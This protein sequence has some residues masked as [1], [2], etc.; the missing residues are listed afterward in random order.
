MEEK[1]SYLSFK[2]GAEYYAASVN[3]VHNI[4]E[5]T[6]ITKVPEMPKYMLGV[7]NLR[8]QVLPVIDSR[9]KFGISDTS[10][11]SNTCILVMEVNIEGSQTFVGALVDAVAEVIEIDTAEI[12][13]APSIG[14]TVRNDFIAGVYHDEEKFIMILEMD[15]VFAS[16]EIINIQ[17]IAEKT[18]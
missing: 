2:I 9:I 12:K 15:K 5:H 8:G 7:I 6:D 11:T 4:I 1:T 10:I 14:T 16:S 3:Y 18:I 13:E 17:E